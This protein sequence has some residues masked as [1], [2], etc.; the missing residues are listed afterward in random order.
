MTKTE[1]SKV[2]V[3]V[4][5]AAEPSVKAEERE[6]VEVKA[7]PSDGAAGGAQGVGEAVIGGARG[8]RGR[9]GGKQRDAFLKAFA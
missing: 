5:S 2:D 1:V 6:P 3:V 8:G 9:G 4:P 7:E